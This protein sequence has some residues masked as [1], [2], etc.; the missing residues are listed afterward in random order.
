V[1]SDSARAERLE[2]AVL[3]AEV[4]GFTRVSAI[5]EPEI[6]IA[7][8]SEFFAMVSA[9]VET[10]AGVVRSVLNDNLVA[11]FG[12]PAHA[13]HAIESAQEI[14]RN[15]AQIEEAWQRDYGLRTAVAIG[16]H[17]G[18]VVVG[19]ASGSARRIAMG[20]GVSMAERLLHR[21]R[22]GETVFSQAV[23]DGVDPAA[24]TADIEKLPA[25]NVAHREPLAIYA[26]ALDTR[27]DFT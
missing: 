13:L 24:I 23:M 12:G 17:R 8:I 18:E 19:P 22:S 6:V 25:M 7:R 4:R 26:I 16:I 20:D 3:Y 10:R 5:L 15:F 2:L 21:A 14:Q 9:A 11:T 1:K 27:L